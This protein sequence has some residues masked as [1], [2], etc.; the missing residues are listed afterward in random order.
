MAARRIKGS[1]ADIEG[2]N[3]DKDRRDS[4]VNYAYES[5]FAGRLTGPLIALGLLALMSTA[6]YYERNVLVSTHYTT[7]R[8]LIL[9]L[10][11]SVA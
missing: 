10:L 9:L 7:R 11:N 6:A 5:A 3:D 2:V 8:F 1:T 4:S